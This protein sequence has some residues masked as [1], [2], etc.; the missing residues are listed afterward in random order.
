MTKTTTVVIPK[1]TTLAMLRDALAYKFGYK[2]DLGM[3]RLEIKTKTAFD[4]LATLGR[5]L[6]LNGKTC[7][8]C[9]AVVPKQQ[10]PKSKTKEAAWA[11][12]VPCGCIK[13]RL[14]ALLP[15]PTT[16]T[17]DPS[18]V[19]IVTGIQNGTISREDVVHF[20][21]CV[22]PGCKG[23]FVTYAHQVM[24]AIKNM[25]IDPA[26]YRWG[27]RCTECRKAAQG[28]KVSIGER[29]SN[30]GEPNQQKAAC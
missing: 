29:V 19:A 26:K 1:N 24:S 3:K 25:K 18:A 21:P 8:F 23:E 7:F 12:Y 15:Q 5:D 20:G 9:G 2:V 22:M 10:K 13:H 6:S 14:A 11:A 28:L 17:N 30:A 27:H 4:K 16:R